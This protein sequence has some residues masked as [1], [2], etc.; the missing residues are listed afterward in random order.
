MSQ[1]FG[2]LVQGIS[3]PIT[4]DV[5]FTPFGQAMAARRQIVQQLQQ[6]I[7]KYRQTSS[8]PAAAAAA[9]APA[10]PA[11][12]CQSQGS[13]PPRALLQTLLQTIDNTH[14]AIITDDQLLDVLVSLLVAGHDTTASTLGVALYYLGTLPAV[15]ER[16][17]QEQ[18]QL[19][20]KHGPDVTPA[21]LEDMT[22]TG[23][24]GC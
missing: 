16:L 20:A 11:T 1:L 13:P 3:F 15:A 2:K 18:L 24:L 8:T 5:P 23:K 17:R 12:T 22:Y 14:D 19:V 10:R 21:C 7:A 4:W 6:Q 9:A